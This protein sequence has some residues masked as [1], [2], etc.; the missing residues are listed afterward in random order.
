M[1]SSPKGFPTQQRITGVAN[2][3]NESFNKI[4]G[5]HSTI[6]PTD[7]GLRYALDV[8]SRFAFRVGDISVPRTAGVNTNSDGPAT[9]IHDTSTPAKKGDFVRFTTGNAQFLELPVIKTEANGFW[10][11]AK[12]ELNQRPASGD[13]FFI[14]RYITQRT[15]ETGSQIVT[16]T[17]GPITFRKDGF[18]DEVEEDTSTPVNNRPLPTKPMANPVGFFGYE[19]SGG[20]IV[21]GSYLSLFTASDYAT[22]IEIDNTTG[23]SLILAFGAASSEV[24]QLIIPAK[25]L[26]RQAVAIPAG[27]EISVKAQFSDTEGVGEV[28]INLFA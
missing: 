18:A 23:K 19:V 4:A 24:D 9:F 21:T 7:E 22:E 27:T 15:D 20:D 11:A 14:M 28:N 10:V 17:Q 26:S 5:E 12:L 6:Q 1:S 13:E 2:S 3:S 16:V 8:I 25:G